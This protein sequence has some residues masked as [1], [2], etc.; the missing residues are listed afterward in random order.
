MSAKK[1][2]RAQTEKVLKMRNFYNW[3]KDKFRA[4]HPPIKG[5]SGPVYISNAYGFKKAKDAADVFSGKKPGFAYSRISLGSPTVRR[6]EK[7]LL[8]LEIGNR[9]KLLK[10]YDALATCSGM[11]AIAILM[12]TLADNKRTFISSPYLYG[13]THHLFK[14]FFPRL[15]IKCIFVKNPRDLKDWE[16]A[17]KKS[18]APVCLY[19]E[20]DANPTPFKLD[21]RALA[22]LAHKYKIPYICDRTIGTPIL[23]KPILSGTDI[24]VHSVTKD[25]SGFSWGLGGVII[26]KKSIIKNM[27]YGYFPVFGPILDGSVAD[28][29][30]FGLK[31]LRQRMR[32]KIKNTKLVKEFLDKH[33]LIKRVYGPGGDLLAFEIRGNYNDAR[34]FVEALKLIIFVPHLGDIRTLAIHP[35]STTHGALSKKDR[36]ELGITD[37]LVRISVGIEDSRDIIDDLAQAFKKI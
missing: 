27:R 10:K 19:A 5:L 6:L 1:K 36:E 11:S 17:I 21:N 30:L 24:V 22:R 23:E 32:I 4:V 29:I 37:T 2:F 31:S 26:A 25:M 14:D 28:R 3:K 9:P 7:E 15:G 13:G 16:H 12:L 18:K 33:S 34:K 20:D 35:A 8:K